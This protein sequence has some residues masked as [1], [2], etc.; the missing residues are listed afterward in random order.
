MTAV[1]AVK[2]AGSPAKTRIDRNDPLAVAKLSWDL[3][4]RIKKA[5][6]KNDQE[7][8]LLCIGTDR[9]TGDCLGPLVGSKVQAMSSQNKLFVYGTLDDPVHAS[10]LHVKL[11]EIFARFKKPYV[12]AVDACLG[13]IESVGHISVGD[14]SLLPGAG[15][16]KSLPAV[17]DIYITGTVNVGGYLEYLVL[18]NTRL[19]VVMKMADL[20]AE[21]ICRM[22]AHQPHQEAVCAGQ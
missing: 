9:S 11:G 10:N 13:S 15:V 19:N 8:I 6:I 14:G 2:E 21:G 12:I 3:T 17:G 4:E 7:K 5:G 16:N 1:N 22:V 18:Q 20:I